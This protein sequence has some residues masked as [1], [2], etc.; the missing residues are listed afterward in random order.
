MLLVTVAQ[1]TKKEVNIQNLFK[2][3][4]K[5]NFFQTAQTKHNFT[6]Y[7]QSFVMAFKLTVAFSTASRPK[8]IWSWL[9]II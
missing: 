9:D 4:E 2:G 5:Q 6:K 1:F 7:N 3:A 8:V